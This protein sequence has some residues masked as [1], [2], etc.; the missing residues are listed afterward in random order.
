M[1]R[2]VTSKAPVPASS[3]LVTPSTFAT[4]VFAVLA[5]F[6]VLIGSSVSWAQTNPLGLG[7]VT[8]FSP[9]SSCPQGAHGSL[10]L[11]Q[12]ACY[13]ATVANCSSHQSGVTIPP[14]NATVAISTPS[15]PKG[16]IFLHGGGTGGDYFDATDN[17][18]GTSYANQ[19]FDSGFQ[20]VQIAWAGNWANNANNPP[21]K[22][23]KYEACRPAT[24]LNYVYTNYG[25]GKAM[26]AQGHSAGSAAMAYALAWYGAGSYLNDVVLTSG[27]VFANVAAGCQY[28]YPTQ[29][30]NPITVCPAGQLGCIG[31]S[32]TDSVQYLVSD[33]TAMSVAQATTNNPVANCNNYNGSGSATTTS[34]DTN[35]LAMSVVSSGASYSYPNTSLSAFLCATGQSQNNSAAQGQLFYKNFTS[36]S[37]TLSYAVYR[38]NNCGGDEMIWDGTTSDGSSAFTVSADAMINSCK[39]AAPGDQQ[40]QAAREL[41]LP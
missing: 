40:A 31:S 17:G 41:S 23:L 2:T 36:S 3:G 7:N 8:Q 13:A 39:L 15:S 35:W 10:P 34:Q 1:T 19:Y 22:V 30:K 32:W 29:F 14:L 11:P 6:T 9:L 20:V 33:G 37:Q 4:I 16:T 26:C 38:V 18:Q 27:P 25:S 12:A 21:V 28:P 24:I 5:T